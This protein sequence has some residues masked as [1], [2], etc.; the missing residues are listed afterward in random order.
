M[1]CKM[2]KGTDS[3]GPEQ[4]RLPQAEEASWEFNPK[5]LGV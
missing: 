5:L 2:G 3:S 4:L 1:R